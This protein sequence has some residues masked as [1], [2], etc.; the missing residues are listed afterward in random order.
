MDKLEKKPAVRWLMDIPEQFN[1]KIRKF[2]G[3]Y[4]QE[5]G[6]L[7]TTLEN[8]LITKW[9]FKERLYNSEIEHTMA[10]LPEGVNW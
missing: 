1:L 4:L 7:I 6:D 2:S 3:W 8:E 5:S 10:V 9:E